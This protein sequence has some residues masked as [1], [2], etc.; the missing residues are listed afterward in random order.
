ML[1]VENFYYGLVPQNVTLVR[2]HLIS[3]IPGGAQPSG[4]VMFMATYE[5]AERC[6]THSFGNTHRE[7]PC[8]SLDQS[9]GVLLPHTCSLHTEKFDSNSLHISNMCS[10]IIDSTFLVSDS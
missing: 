5:A 3:C 6:Q 9:Q 1:H 10:N 2:G 8:R 7:L 4:T